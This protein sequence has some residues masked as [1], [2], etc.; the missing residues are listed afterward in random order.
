MV[1]TT[2]TCQAHDM[3][4][5][6]AMRP[7]WTAMGVWIPGGYG[8]KIKFNLVRLVVWFGLRFF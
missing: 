1:V 5:P 6:R 2:F 4:W 7:Q 3:P 8:T